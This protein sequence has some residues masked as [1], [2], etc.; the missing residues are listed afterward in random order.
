MSDAITIDEVQVKLRED[1]MP[2][3][4]GKLFDLLNIGGFF[5]PHE[6]AYGMG[7]FDEHLFKGEN[8][9]YQFMLYEQEHMILACGCYGLL[10]L[11][12]KRYHL[13]WIAVADGYHKHGIG[14]RLEAAIVGRIRMQGGVKV[15]AEVSNRAYHAR[16]RKFYELCGYRIGVTIPDYYGTGDDKLLYVKDV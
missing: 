13:H 14:S 5:Y 11:T 9:S 8:S 2:G 1:V 12:N 6:M 7:L 15:Y 4:R 10:P 3:D 16:A